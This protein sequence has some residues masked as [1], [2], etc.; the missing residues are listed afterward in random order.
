GGAWAGQEEEGEEVAEKSQRNEG[1]ARVNG[2][3]VCKK[4]R[5]D[6]GSAANHVSRWIHVS[7]AVKVRGFGGKVARSVATI[8]TL[9][10]DW[11]P[12]CG[13]TNSAREGRGHQASE[14]GS[15]GSGG[16]MVQGEGLARQRSGRGVV[17]ER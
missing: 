9:E 10:L 11:M 8:G 6:N 15:G 7:H 5:G 16:E 4:G 14:R 1:E 2:Q 12:G 13:K 3:R 17:R